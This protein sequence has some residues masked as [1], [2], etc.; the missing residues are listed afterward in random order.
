[1]YKS[2]FVLLMKKP[3]V[4]NL[5]NIKTLKPIGAIIM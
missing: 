4:R 3:S 2:V 1:M 5:A